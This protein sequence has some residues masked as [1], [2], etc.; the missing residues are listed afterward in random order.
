[1]T[2]AD[3]RSIV[4]KVS[5][6]RWQTVV[7]GVSALAAGV[8]MAVVVSGAA[9]GPSEREV[10]ILGSGDAI[11]IAGSPESEKLTVSGRENECCLTIDGATFSADAEGCQPDSG[12]G[13]AVCNVSD[14]D[15]VQANL[16]GGGDAMTLV[17]KFRI[18]TIRGETGADTIVGGSGSQVIE[19]QNG[20][21]KL[22]GGDGPDRLDGG[23]GEDRCKGG[24]SRDVVK[25]CEHGGD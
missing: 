9:A 7:A 24:G 6:G 11:T 8:A 14:Y 10:T 13:N 15:S 4:Q 19:G 23:K 12:A 2:G 3:K 25:H 17:D 16:G 18:I 21:D 20:D 22:D 5:R 1:L